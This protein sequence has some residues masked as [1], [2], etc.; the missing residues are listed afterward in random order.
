MPASCRFQY[1]PV[2]AN[3]V[4]ASRVISKAAGDSC[5]RHSP[6]LLTTFG[7]RTVSSRFPTSEK[8][9]IV[10]R[11]APPGV[12]AGFAST[13]GLLF[14]DHS[15]SPA[16]AHAEPK[17]KARRPTLLSTGPSSR[18]ISLIIAAPVGIRN[19]TLADPPQTSLFLTEVFDAYPAA[20]HR[21]QRHS[22]ACFPAGT[23]QI[24]QR[25]L[26]LCSPP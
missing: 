14:Q 24:M 21:G 17:R 6:S 18:S 12:A 26:L 16:S 20:P 13:S 23:R 3:S 2:K 7:T 9:T 11:C 5:F 25:Q 15:A 10:T 1:A 19:R 4:P 22:A 8:R